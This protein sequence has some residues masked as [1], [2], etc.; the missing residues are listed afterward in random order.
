MDSQKRSSKS[1]LKKMIDIASKKLKNDKIDKFLKD[2]YSRFKSKLRKVMTGDEKT[3]VRDHMLDL[4]QT[5]EN[6][7]LFDKVSFTMGVIHLMLT[8]FFFCSL[9]SYFW[10]YATF[11]LVSS[12]LSR[13]FHYK[14]LD[15]E[16]FLFDFCY[17]SDICNMLSAIYFYDS[18][19]F[20]KMCFILANG[21]L[22]WAIVVWRNSLVFHDFDKVT[23]VYIHILPSMLT[24]VG[25]THGHCSLIDF[26]L[27]RTQ[28]SSTCT[29]FS[30]PMMKGDEALATLTLAD[31]GRAV[32]FYVF[33]QVCYY[34]KTEVIDKEYLDQ[35]PEKST[36]LR[37]IATD[38]KNAL[39]RAIL[40]LLRK[41][42]V[43]GANEDFDSHSA[44]TK[45]TFMGSQLIYT[46]V[47]FMPC[48][49]MFRWPMFHFSFLLFVVVYAIYNGASFYFDVF[50]LRYQPLVEKTTVPLKNRKKVPHVGSKQG[51]SSA[52]TASTTPTGLAT[53]TTTSPTAT[54]TTHTKADSAGEA[55]TAVNSLI[56]CCDEEGLGLE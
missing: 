38:T 42:N 40:M 46:M 52:S 1:K 39:A 49:F 28:N 12:V 15:F 3:R 48:Y 23:S 36:S 30:Q 54:L 27:F 29:L 4:Q 22:L 14:S 9:P 26:M 13:Y 16:Y 6:Y 32:G 56:E 8:Q 10:V 47:T 24:Y 41:V 35:H 34:I 45:I 37:W 17:F 18:V 53:A 20:F 21:P 33:W 31:F 2:N 7:K 51:L 44:K 50:S 43:Y 55:E 11:V 25:L 5:T 19:W